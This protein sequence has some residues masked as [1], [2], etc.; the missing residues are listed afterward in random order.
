MAGLVPEGSQSGA[1]KHGSKMQEPLHQGPDESEE[2][3]TSYGEVCG[4][5][6]AMGLHE[7]LLRGLY[8]HGFKEPYAVQQRGIIPFCRGL[9]VVQQAP[10]GTGKTATFC[11][12]ILQRLDYGLVECQ[13]IVLVPTREDGQRAEKILRALGDYSG[14][15]VH[16]C[17]GGTSVRTDRRIVETGIHVIIGTPGRI[18]DM[19]GLSKLRRQFLRPEFLK[20]FVVDDTDEVYSRFKKEIYD[21][22]KFLPSEIQVGIS[23]TTMP[24]EVLAIT[25]KFMKT[26][27]R[28]HV[29]RKERPTLD[30]IKQF[31]VDVEKEDWKLETLLDMY[32]T[33]P[34]T[35]SVVFVNTRCKVDWLTNN[36]REKDHTVAAMHGD[37]DQKARDIIMREFRSGSARVLITTDLACAI[38][39]RSALV[40]NYDMPNKPENYLHRVGRSDVSRKGVAINFVTRDD[41]R[42][43]QDIQRF[44]NVTI[45]ELPANAADLL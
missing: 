42:L 26:P 14:V 32:E 2:D 3:F 6:D 17:V 39:V 40:I 27:V 8:A 11:S 22:F 24:P 34:I 30:G 38:D 41:E 9:D 1:K 28:I 4:S 29:K 7:N 20:M 44:Y 16:A 18:L 10:S 35:T 25:D 31:T 21:I 13:A 12:G 43:M 5:F 45:E 23:S 37:M 36:L 33:L 19:L 15:K